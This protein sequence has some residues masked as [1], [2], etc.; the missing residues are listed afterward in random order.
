MQPGS[1]AP[2]YWKFDASSRGELAVQL[3]LS[4]RSRVGVIPKVQL[5]GDINVKSM[6]ITGLYARLTR[7]EREISSSWG[8]RCCGSWCS[9]TGKSGGSGSSRESGRLGSRGEG[10][11]REREIGRVG[12]TVVK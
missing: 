11:S 3:W 4:L 2:R 10:G 1:A 5:P 12:V 6:I 8:R 9:S 7:E